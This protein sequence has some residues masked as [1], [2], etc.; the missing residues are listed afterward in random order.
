[1]ISKGNKSVFHPLRRGASG[2]SK[3]GESEC[4]PG[5]GQVRAELEEVESGVA[6]EDGSPERGMSGKGDMAAA[7]GTVGGGNLAREGKSPKERDDSGLHDT[8]SENED[9][10]MSEEDD[11]SSRKSALK[12]KEEISQR[13][14]G[15]KP[16]EKESCKKSAK[17]KE[18]APKQKEKVAPQK[19]MEI[20]V[21]D[22]SSDE[23]EVADEA[24]KDGRGGKQS[25]DRNSIG[26]LQ[27]Q[28]YQQQQQQR[29]AEKAHVEKS[30]T[31]GHGNIDKSDAVEDEESSKTA[32]HGIADKD[33]AVEY[34]ESSEKDDSQDID[35]ITPPAEENSHEEEEGSN[36]N[37]DKADQS[38][39]CTIVRSWKKMPWLPNLN[40]LINQELEED[41]MA[42]EFEKADQSSN[43]TELEDDAMAAEFENDLFDLVDQTIKINHQWNRRILSTFVDSLH[44]QQQ[45][46][47]DSRGGGGKEGSYDIDHNDNGNGNDNG[48]NES[49]ADGGV[50]P[51]ESEPMD[52]L[53]AGEAADNDK[54]ASDTVVG[55]HHG[56]ESDDQPDADGKEIN[57]DEDMQIDDKDMRTDKENIDGGH[58][59]NPV[60][61][62]AAPRRGKVLPRPEFPVESVDG[63]VHPRTESND[64]SDRNNEK[65]ATNT[66]AGRNQGSDD[67]SSDSVSNEVS[68]GSRGKVLPGPK[69][70][71]ESSDGGDLH[72]RIESNKKLDTN[73]DK[74]SESND[75]PETAEND[76]AAT[77][78]E[79]NVGG[80]TI[81]GNAD[82][83]LPGSELSDD[84]SGADKE[85][86]AS[87]IS[88]ETNGDEDVQIDDTDMRS[89]KDNIDGGHDSNSLDTPAASA[90]A[91]AVS[92]CQGGA[93]E[94]E[95]LAI[96]SQN[97]KT[98]S[99]KDK[100]KLQKEKKKQ[101]KERKKD[102]RKEKR[103][104]SKDGE[105]RMNAKKQKQ[106]G[107]DNNG[108]GMD[109]PW[110]EEE[111]R[112]YLQG[113]EQCGQNNWGK[114]ASDYV[115]TR[116]PH[117]IREYARSLLGQGSNQTKQQH[118]E[119]MELNLRVNE[120]Q[121]ME[122]NN[123]AVQEMEASN[124][125]K[126][127]DTMDPTGEFFLILYYLL[128]LFFFEE[129]YGELFEVP[130]AEV[131][132]VDWSIVCDAIVLLFSLDET[133]Y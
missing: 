49:N 39:N 129:E 85:P 91:A 22:D 69:F 75:T 64:K 38:S 3:R 109:M 46:E 119:S 19:K 21:L 74:G 1:M 53:D 9:R 127:N 133:D 110:T 117:Q 94:K 32:G 5:D 118:V 104:L 56:I 70:P 78:K 132:F 100:K 115:T 41:A 107:G 113:V 73:N 55:V 95:G 12:K 7:A 2:G 29:Q 52:E 59:S 131:G 20:I 103:K 51:G 80:N 8:E 61:T 33:D 11:G 120:V 96:S 17:Q 108:Q 122:S 99:N 63:G 93:V 50:Q 92:I 62:S 4:S 35:Q 45:E 86:P 82:V 28:H 66:A 81:V 97:Q 60:D 123:D 88:K 98:A 102:E 67:S 79:E 36:E 125:G 48:K 72:P 16:H 65:S 24:V 112:L 26:S 6:G 57:G 18:S 121:E 68:R 47:S 40:Q 83:N 101:K 13:N 44:E 71:V 14:A 76:D 25:L 114:I 130:A 126:N 87:P 58:D 37:G 23:D 128:P 30:K 77:G 42:A 89:A 31:G 106:G 34:E 15:T 105:N 116:T 124:D 84:P 43:G 27:H 111:K 10:S 54:S 90:A